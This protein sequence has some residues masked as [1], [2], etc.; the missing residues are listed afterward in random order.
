M[1]LIDLTVEAYGEYLRA[2][3][4]W[5]WVV[6]LRSMMEI[7]SIAAEGE[8]DQNRMCVDVTGWVIKFLPCRRHK[9][10]T[11]KWKNYRNL[12]KNLKLLIYALYVSK[13]S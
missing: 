6:F 9:W 3:F 5:R 2:L 13:L 12:C 7:R 11:P 8:A 4:F 1:Y 10:M